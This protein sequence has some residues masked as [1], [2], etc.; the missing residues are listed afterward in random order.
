MRFRAAPFFVLPHQPIRWS[1]HTVFF[2]FVYMKNSL[3]LFTIIRTFSLWNSKKMHISSVCSVH[4][5]FC[6]LSRKWLASCSMPFAK[7]L[8]TGHELNNPLCESTPKWTERILRIFTTLTLV[9]SATKNEGDKFQVMAKTRART[10]KFNKAKR[11]SKSDI[12]CCRHRWLCVITKRWCWAI[13]YG[14]I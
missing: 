10:N 1:A 4:H 2:Y 14:N 11:K 3:L 12:V 7:Y 8:L 13:N 5:L 9:I 6:W